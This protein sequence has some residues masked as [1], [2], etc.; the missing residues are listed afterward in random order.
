LESAKES[1]QRAGKVA[2]FTGE[3]EDREKNYIHEI[4]L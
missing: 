4:I 2:K 3:Y 1:R